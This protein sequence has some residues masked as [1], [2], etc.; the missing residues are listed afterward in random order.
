MSRTGRFRARQSGFT[1]IE[2]VVVLA[3][4]A[5]VTALAVPYLARGNASLTT[6]AAAREIAAALRTTRSLAMLHGRSAAFTL[7]TA[8]GVYRADVSGAPHRL[9][10]GLRLAL[11]TTTAERT[12]ATVGNIRFYADGSSDGGGVLLGDDNK[13]TEVLVDWL[14]GSV[15]IETEAHH[16]A[17]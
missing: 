4:L 6:T 7:D 2:V 1:L 8:R 5:L 12:D 9:P 17:R 10:K 13:L 11:V 16:A 15:T 14:T 3:I